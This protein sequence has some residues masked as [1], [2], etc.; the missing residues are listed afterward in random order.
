MAGYTCPKCGCSAVFEDGGKL[1]CLNC[2]HTFAR[3]GAK[4]DGCVHKAPR[5]ARAPRPN[6]EPRAARLAP[7]P[8]A[9]PPIPDAPP[10]KQGQTPIFARTRRPFES[11]PVKKQSVGVLIAVVA[12][13]LVMLVVSRLESQDDFF[14]GSDYEEYEEYEEAAAVQSYSDPDQP[15][16]QVDDLGYFQFLEDHYRGDGTVEVPAFVNGHAVTC[17]DVDAFY[18]CTRVDYVY[19]AEGITDI[20]GWSFEGC[21]GLREIYLPEGLEWLPDNFIVDCPDV[22][23]IYF[24]GTEA[25]WD[26]LLYATT[27]SDADPDWLV[28]HVVFGE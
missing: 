21:I 1:Q 18:N 2:G 20:S 25:E 27:S 5:P 10:K 24:P 7:E 19:I 16:A 4:R 26:E 8:Q 6:P 3:L 22:E 12:L 28:E 15:W 17:I 14:G 9:A 13:F 23:V 11:A